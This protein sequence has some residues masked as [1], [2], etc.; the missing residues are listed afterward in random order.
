MK[1]LNDFLTF[2]E[3]KKTYIV[4]PGMGLLNVAVALGYIS[5]AH[6]DQINLVLVALGLGTLRAAKK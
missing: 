2:L 4:A 6:L 5:P 1:K 3:G